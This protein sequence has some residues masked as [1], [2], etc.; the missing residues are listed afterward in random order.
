M[1]VNRR[2]IELSKLHALLVTPVTY[3]PPSPSQ[4]KGGPLSLRGGDAYDCN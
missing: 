4:A 3:L 1:Y 2:V